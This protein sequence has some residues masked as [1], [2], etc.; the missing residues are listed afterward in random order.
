MNYQ[1]S[2]RAGSQILVMTPNQQDVY[3]DFVRDCT[4]NYP[5]MKYVVNPK[6]I[7][8]KATNHRMVSRQSYCVFPISSKAIR[9]STIT[10]EEAEKYCQEHFEGHLISFS[11]GQEDMFLHY[12]LFRSFGA[13]KDGESSFLT[14]M[15]VISKESGTFTDGSSYV[16]ASHRVEFNQSETYP[17]CGLLI[18]NYRGRLDTAIAKKCESYDRFACKASLTSSRF[19][20][21]LLPIIIGIS[22]SLSVVPL[23]L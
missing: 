6:E 19:D 18:R 16:Y 13:M 20:Y 5:K 8:L 2:T 10:F 22:I 21:R 1:R 3:E 11:D 12:I 4:I 14:G 17:L 15:R 23:I 9:N 7:S